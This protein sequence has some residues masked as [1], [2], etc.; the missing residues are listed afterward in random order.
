MTTDP[1]ALAAASDH[2]LRHTHMVAGEVDGLCS[3]RRQEETQRD[4]EDGSRKKRD[5]D[6]DTEGQKTSEDRA[7]QI[8]KARECDVRC[9]VH[10]PL[11]G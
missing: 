9:D 10:H 6:R 8:G 2:A 4:T 1:V 3:D 5:A 7:C 11:G